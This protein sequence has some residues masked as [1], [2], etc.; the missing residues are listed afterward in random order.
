MS[1][2]IYE[3]KISILDWCIIFAAI[4]LLL[5]VYLP[6]RIWVE[7]AEFKKEGR[8][9]MSDIAN[10]QEFYFEL[11]GNFTPDGEHLFE[12]VE[13]A[14]DSLIADSLFTG[15]QII[16]LSDSAYSVTLETGFEV[17]AD[18]TFSNPVDIKNV[19]QDTV[20]TVGMKNVESG[21]TDTLFVNSKDLAKYQADEHFLSAFGSE[22][23]TRSEIIT[24]YLRKKYHL[25][26]EKLNC[27]ITNDPFIFEIDTSDAAEAVFSVISPL[28]VLEE[29]FTE[30]RFGVFSFE[31]GDHGYI[32]GGVKSWAGD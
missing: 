30:S 12:L 14:I 2:Q 15:E 23:V 7:E 11:T 21:G 26:A 13:A 18:T 27:P 16:Q 8:Q 6:Q 32:R 10:A 19:Y 31:A 22:I 5:T 25:G 28:H 17:R 4:L 3:R 20:Y 9:R 24:D 1:D 29:P